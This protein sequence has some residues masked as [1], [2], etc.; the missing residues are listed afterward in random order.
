MAV[1]VSLELDEK[2]ITVLK[3]RFLAAM[4][5]TVDEDGFPRIAPVSLFSVRDSKTIFTAMQAGCR[6]AG[7]IR[8]DGKI[9]LNLCEEGDLAAGIRGK[10]TILGDSKAFRG[11]A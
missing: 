4:L 11:G 10:A 5:A 3:T 1:S 7:N 2:I 9:M 6:S 8:R